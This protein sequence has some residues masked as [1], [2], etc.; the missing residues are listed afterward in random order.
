MHV[1]MARENKG[2][3]AF[4]GNTIKDFKYWDIWVCAKSAGLGCSELTMSLVNVLLK[5][6][7][8]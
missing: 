6:Q 2:V 8:F 3:M 5:F 4:L 7:R 1:H